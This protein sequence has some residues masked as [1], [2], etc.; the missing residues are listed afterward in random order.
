M[1]TAATPLFSTSEFLSFAWAKVKL[2]VQPVLMLGLVGAILAGLNHPTTAGGHAWGPWNLLVQL[3]QM[4]VTMAWIRFAFQIVDETPVHVPAPKELWPEFLSF[5][6]ASILCGLMIGIGF[7][8][9][10]VPGVVL[11]LTYGFSTFVV[12]DQKLGPLDALKE[13]ARL[14]KGVRA[15][16]FIFGV[17]MLLLNL[18]GLC[19]FG[20]G[21][22]ATIPMTFIA[23]AKVFR[24]LQ[25]R[26]GAA[27]PVAPTQPSSN[28]P[29]PV[30]VSH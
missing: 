24:R 8:F 15:D 5:V 3:A 2:H 18:A 22:F 1:T 21:L 13:S 9:L 7:V 30:V 10:I 26:A 28:Q 11:A 4:G 12:M 19:A 16:L 29:P 20:V 27:P 25:V 6:A 14:T 17:I 23:S